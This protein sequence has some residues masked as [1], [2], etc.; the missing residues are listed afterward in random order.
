[1]RKKSANLRECVGL[2]PP[3]N[4]P[5]AFFRR[6]ASAQANR[7]RHPL[8]GRPDWKNAGEFLVHYVEILSLPAH[9]SCGSDFSLT[10]YCFNNP[11]C[12]VAVAISHA[13]PKGRRATN[14]AR[15]S[16]SERS[17]RDSRRFADLFFSSRPSPEP[18]TKKS[19]RRP[20][21]THQKIFF[22]LPAHL[23][24]TAQTNP[25]QQKT[26]KTPHPHAN[27]KTPSPCT[28][29]RTISHPPGCVAE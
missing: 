22:F 5:I 1:M 18:A 4:S 12:A 9:H 17:E 3:P 15:D 8:R 14:S 25:Q 7:L 28:P 27:T 16:L 6:P 24:R 29:T 11:A 13:G 23:R 10:T 19:G 20:A 2:R 21:T 26:K